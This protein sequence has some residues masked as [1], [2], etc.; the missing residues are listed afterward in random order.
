MKPAH[1]LGPWVWV[2]RYTLRPADPRPQESAVHTIL[3]LECGGCGF[4]MSE[5]AAT[6]AELDADMVL[7]ASEPDMLAELQ[8][9]LR[10]HDQ[11][12]P[13]DVQRLRDVIEKATAPLDPV[14]AR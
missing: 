14:L 3:D 4:V 10:W 6:S 1:T 13:S 11:L 5:P 9:V 12:G 7:I 8:H 2:D